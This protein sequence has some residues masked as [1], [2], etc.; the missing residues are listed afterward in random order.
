MQV[1]HRISEFDVQDIY[2]YCEC[3]YYD[4]TSH[5]RAAV[6]QESSTDN[7]GDIEKANQNRLE[8]GTI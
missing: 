8:I 6:N 4:G 2:V 1:S 3:C 5:C 7:I